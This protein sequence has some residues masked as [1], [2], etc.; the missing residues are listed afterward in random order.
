MLKR[1]RMNTYA[2]VARGASAANVILAANV[3]QQD[4]LRG[5]KKLS[6]A[7]RR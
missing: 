5:V 3:C 1:S 2:K 4:E 6:G 7:S